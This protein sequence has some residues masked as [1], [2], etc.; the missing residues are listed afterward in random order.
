MR[1]GNRAL[2]EGNPTLKMVINIIDMTMA[3][4]GLKYRFVFDEPAL[5]GV[6]G[7]GFAG[8]LSRQVKPDGQ[9]MRSAIEYMCR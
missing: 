1:Q 5:F 2:I 9:F 7:C 6:T 8:E 3:V 4:A